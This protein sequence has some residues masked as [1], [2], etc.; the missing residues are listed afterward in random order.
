MMLALFRPFIRTTNKSFAASPASICT[1]AALSIVRLH[2]Q[3]QHNFGTRCWNIC[4]V[5][6]LSAAAWI[7]AT[8]LSDANHLQSFV[9]CLEL[10]QAMQNKLCI[11]IENIFTSMFPFLKRW[12]KLTPQIWQA[13]MDV[14]AYDK[15]DGVLGRALAACSPGPMAFGDAL[16]SASIDASFA[17]WLDGGSMTAIGSG[18]FLQLDDLGFSDSL[19][20][21]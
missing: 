1:E 5:N 13:C 16:D 20:S 3:Q 15:Q 7:F 17:D 9:Q 10:L 14:V 12:N 8:D 2:L 11:P 21:S 6:H 19:P 18:P 4:S